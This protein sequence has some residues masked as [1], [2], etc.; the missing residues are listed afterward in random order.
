MK[1]FIRVIQKIMVDICYVGFLTKNKN[2]YGQCM[3]CCFKK[4]QFRYK[5]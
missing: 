4:N 2:P 5:K 1:F 3:P